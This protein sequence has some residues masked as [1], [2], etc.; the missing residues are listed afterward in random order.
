M[1]LALLPLDLVTDCLP[2]GLVK[3]V[4]VQYLFQVPSLELRRCRE[5]RS[6]CQHCSL[7]IDCPRDCSVKLTKIRYVFQDRSLS[8]HQA[9]ARGSNDV[10]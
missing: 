5:L 10:L 2:D 6:Y 1:D 8:I 9:N 7:V 4:D 3:L